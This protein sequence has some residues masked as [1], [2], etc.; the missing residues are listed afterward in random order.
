MKNIICL[1]LMETLIARNDEIFASYLSDILELK[2]ISDYELK[3]K[4]RQRYIEYSFGNFHDDSDYVENLVLTFTGNKDSGN[5]IKEIT[6]HLL[7]HY[8]AIDGSKNFL[9]TLKGL[10]YQ[11]YAASNFVTSWAEELLIRLD[12]INYF[13]GVFVSS[14]IRYRK[15][16]RE[17]FDYIKKKLNRSA[18][19]MYFIGNSY[20]NDYLGA[21]TAGMSP[22]LLKKN[23]AIGRGATY[24]EIIEQLSH[25]N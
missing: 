17:F 15:P 1:D 5:L 22:I 6:A 7:D 16:A 9:S 24:T 8:W 23:N 21:Q 13:N 3:T 18:D 25:T 20:V 12:M 10:G 11:I 2:G 14:D 4:I 19:E